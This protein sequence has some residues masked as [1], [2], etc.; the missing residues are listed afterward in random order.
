MCDHH[1]SNVPIAA[2]NSPPHSSRTLIRT[3]LLLWSQHD[4][5]N[6]P[7]SF[8]QYAFCLNVNCSAV[9]MRVCR[10]WFSLVNR[11][12]SWTEIQH[13]DLQINYLL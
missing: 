9:A 4:E 11:W 3:S 13:L 1:C 6:G 2:S 5:Q 7:S 8:I 12:F 10:L